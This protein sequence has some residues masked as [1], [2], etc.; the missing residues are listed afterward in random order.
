MSPALT[1]KLSPVA[2]PDP[3]PFAIVAA[4]LFVLCAT[5]CTKNC[6]IVVQPAGAESA[7]TLMVV[8]AALVL[9][10]EGAA[11][12][13]FRATRDRDH[14]DPPPAGRH[15]F[16]S[17]A[18][19][20]GN[21]LARLPVRLADLADTGSEDPERSRALLDVPADFRPLLVSARVGGSRQESE[22]LVSERRPGE[23]ARCSCFPTTPLLNERWRSGERLCH[24][25]KK[26][27][28]RR[29]RFAP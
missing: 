8:A 6:G 21:V 17:S 11:V 25:G 13:V 10:A 12:A 3:E 14:N 26:G 23:R 19:V 22:Q 1:E 2:E 15:H 4:V 28:G 24:D 5:S 9:I 20:V 16:F 29:E 7:I 18:A 27:E